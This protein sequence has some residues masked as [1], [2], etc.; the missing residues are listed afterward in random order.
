MLAHTGSIF[1]TIDGD[2]DAQRTPVRDLCRLLLNERSPRH[3]LQGIIVAVPF[4]ADAANSCRENLCLVRRATG[5]ELPIYFAICGMDTA[6]TGSAPWLQ[7]FPPHPDLDPA[8]ITQMYEIGM[9]SLCL[10]RIPRQ[11]RAGI[12]LAPAALPENIRLFQWQSKLAR[13]R[14]C[15]VKILTEATQNEGAEPGMVAGCYIVPPAT[16]TAG[17]AALLHCDLLK[18]QHSACWTAVT[19]EQDDAQKR[20]VRFGYSMGLFALFTMIATAIAWLALRP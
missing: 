15:I 12:V 1:F 9:D 2:A 6:G 18:H 20:Y 10:E 13:W 5:L 7:R 17:L 4:A 3:P 16:Q 19:V 11:I 8:E 14:T